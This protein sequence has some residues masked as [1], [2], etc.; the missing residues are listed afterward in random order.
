MPQT[1]GLP[2]ELSRKIH[3]IN[4]SNPGASRREVNRYL[5]HPKIVKWHERTTAIHFK[6]LASQQDSPLAIVCCC[7]YKLLRE[8]DT[9][10]IRRG[11]CASYTYFTV[12]YVNTNTD[13]NA[14]RERCLTWIRHLV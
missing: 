12:Q 13:T 1:D 2:T 14:N 3:H 9:A 10:L 8:S 5:D 4:L 6:Q 11:L 7:S